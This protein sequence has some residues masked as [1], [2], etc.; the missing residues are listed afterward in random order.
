MKKLGLICE[1]PVPFHVIDL[2]IWGKETP[3]YRKLLHE[4]YDKFIAS[5]S[6]KLNGL[7]EI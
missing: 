2:R 5:E 3:F 4:A 1:F 6:V 7:G